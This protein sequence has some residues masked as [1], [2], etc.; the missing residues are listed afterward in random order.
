MSGPPTRVGIV[1]DDLTGASDTAAQFVSAGWDTELRLRPGSSTAAVVAVATYSRGFNARDAAAAVAAAV[2]ELRETGI[3]HLY[4]KIDSTLRGQVSAEVQAAVD[5]WSPNAVAVVC[6]AF[7]AMGR[8]VVDGQLRV[9]GVAVSETAA[10]GD[11]ITPVTESHI[12]TLLKAAHLER[13]AGE[14]SRALSDRIRASGPVV[15]VDAASEAEL[16]Q[17]AEA[18]VALGVDIVPVGSAGLARHLASFWRSESFNPEQASS[19]S[20][21]VGSIPATTGATTIVIVTSLQDVARAQIAALVDAGARRCEPSPQ[22]LVDDD[23]WAR[24]SANVLHAF[25]KMPSTWLLTATLDRSTC[26]PPAL[27]P[28]RLADLAARMIKIRTK[29]NVS[30]VVVTGGDGARALTD[31]V[32]ASAIQIDGEVITGVPIGRLVGGSAAGLH[33]VTKAG[34]FGDTS[35]LLRAVEAVCD[36]SI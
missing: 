3:N 36:R 35:T 20:N 33:L 5:S 26:L 25:E 34:G 4:K 14:S 10:G 8:T 2:K 11:P 24:W 17:L 19:S 12:P 30:G 9:D 27:I 22:D 29:R 7:P 6:P 32:E 18:V 23:A 31:A 16:Q 13:N 15:V 1:A 21:D 28:R